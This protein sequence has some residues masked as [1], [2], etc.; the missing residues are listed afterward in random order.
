MKD[1]LHIDYWINKRLNEARHLEK[2][3]PQ[4]PW[5]KRV[6]GEEAFKKRIKKVTKRFLPT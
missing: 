1:N 3:N 4:R 2:P 6:T 5:R